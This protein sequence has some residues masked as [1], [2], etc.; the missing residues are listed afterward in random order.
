[1]IEAEKIDT[2]EAFLALSM[3]LEFESADRLTE[4]ALRMRQHEAEE[5]AQLLDELAVNSEKHASEIQE[6]SDGHVLPELATLDLSWEG[7]E[8]PETTAY[9]SVTAQTQVDEMLQIALRNEIRG[10]DFYANISLRSPSP[11]VRKLAAEFADEENEHV[12]MLQQRIDR[13]NQA[14]RH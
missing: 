4:L 5:L 10:Q 6:L 2:L 11:E 7:L 12:M 3:L 9:G 14:T 13:D 8:G 1:M